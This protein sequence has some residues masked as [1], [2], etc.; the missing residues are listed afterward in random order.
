MEKTIP[1]DFN[2]MF[3]ILTARYIFSSD[4]CDETLGCF[5]MDGVFSQRPFNVNP[6]SRKIVGTK[7]RV[8]NVGLDYGSILYIFIKIC[9]KRPSFGYFI[10]SIIYNHHIQSLQLVLASFYSEDGHFIL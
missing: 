10:N 5:E 2:I 1:I 6:N 9:Y 3:I 7:F 4:Y 8:C